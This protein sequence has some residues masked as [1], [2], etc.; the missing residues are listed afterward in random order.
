MYSINILDTQIVLNIL[1][2][3]FDSNKK[4]KSDILYLSKKDKVFLFIYLFCKIQYFG[5][6][7]W[8]NHNTR[9][10]GF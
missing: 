6:E 9:I 2:F 4:L 8:V 7:F 10:W 3:M 5:N 1:K